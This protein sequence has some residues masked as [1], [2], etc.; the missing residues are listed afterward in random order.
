LIGFETHFFYNTLVEARMKP[1]IAVMIF[2]LLAGVATGADPQ[3]TKNKKNDVSQIG[4]RDVGKCLNFYSLEKEIALG[5][6]LAE[7]VQRQA[8]MNDDPVLGEYVNRI[9]QN[10]ARNSDAKV[11]FTFRI[12]EDDILNAFALPGG[13]I[14]INTGL[15]RIASEEDEFA[16]A[17][18]HE[19]AHVAA[20]HMTCQA[21][22]SQLT[23]LLAIPLGGILGGWGGVAARQ[24]ASVA[25]PAAFL[26]FSRGDE[27]EADF[28]GTQYM[29]AAGYDPNGAISIFEK[30]ESLNRTKP[31]TM[32]KIF[33]TH[34]PDS[35]RIEKTQKEIQEIL[36]AKPEYVV[37]TSEYTQMRER[38]IDA[39]MRRKS[40]DADGRPRLKVAPGNGKVEAQDEKDDRPTIR[41]RDL[42]E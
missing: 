4:N 20:R 25:I 33:S 34:P 2:T 28:L 37:T 26:K 24:G 12:I 5:K 16:G 23:S 9:G 39:Q 31:G 8:K 14:F 30:M 40:Q 3:K 11:P 18:A 32:A 21:T 41:R 1:T 29:Y 42:I 17:I 7:E 36:P 13:P 6:Q 35:S 27:A 15:I 22:K 10:L 19:I 38:L